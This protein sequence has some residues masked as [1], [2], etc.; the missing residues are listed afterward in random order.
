MNL[1]QKKLTSFS[2]KHRNVTISVYQHYDYEDYKVIYE[3]IELCACYNKMFGLG[4]D[5]Y[6]K[7]TKYFEQKN[8]KAVPYT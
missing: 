2:K 5:M 4:F 8:R 7:E 1:V 6:C 3:P